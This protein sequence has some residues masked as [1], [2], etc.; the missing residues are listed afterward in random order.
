M[1]ARLAALA[2]VLA[3][4]ACKKEE[5]VEFSPSQILGRWFWVDAQ[6]LY[7]ASGY[8]GE[9]YAC[10]QEP[11]HEVAIRFDTET[12]ATLDV[13]CDITMLCTYEDGV[14]QECSD[15]AQNSFLTCATVPFTGFLLDEAYE[16]PSD[17]YPGPSWLVDFTPPIDVSMTLD[18]PAWY[19]WSENGY[20]LSADENFLKPEELRIWGTGPD[21][22]SINASMDDGANYLWKVLDSAPARVTEPPFECFVPGEG[23]DE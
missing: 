17:G 11:G 13:R 22:L 23:E 2:A 1:H 19:D 10:D 4:T 9:L 16:P 12:Q 14:R 6:I 15:I 21:G 20:D 18:L 3:L 5:E 8:T 7:S